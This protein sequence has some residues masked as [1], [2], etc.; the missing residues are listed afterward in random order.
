MGEDG[1]G[2]SGMP[3]R[4]SGP[5]RTEVEA[6]RLHVADARL[7]RYASD[8]VDCVIEELPAPWE[9][10]HAARRA[11][12]GALALSTVPDQAVPPP[13]EIPGVID[14]TLLRP[15]ATEAEVE[16]LCADARAYGFASVCVLPRFVP[17]AALALRRS[18]VRVGTVV[19]FPL[20]ASATLV[21][22]VEAAV[23]V[24]QGAR[25]LDMVLAIG[26]LKSGALGAV[27]LDIATVVGTAH[28]GQALVKVI[29]ETVLLSA[30]EQVRACLLARDAGADFVKT[31]TGYGLPGADERDVRRLRALVPPTMGVKAAGGIR[32]RADLE[33]MMRAGATRIGT[34]SGV[35][36]VQ[37]YLRAGSFAPARSGRAAASW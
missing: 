32:T 4:P 30:E 25:E 16:R 34:S 1:R 12:V 6:P 10:D 17:L 36:I 2:G 31:S 14:H 26:A 13:E 8:V 7:L 22:A 19:G 33:R 5:P 3:W 24:E 11:D 15:D 20:G 29:L 27:G 21:K 9:I 23:A 28:A 18:Q 35:K 37:E